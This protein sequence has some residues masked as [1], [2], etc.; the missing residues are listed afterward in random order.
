MLWCTPLFFLIVQLGGMRNEL[1]TLS[2][3]KKDEILGLVGENPIKK[4][5][6]CFYKWME[7]ILCGAYMFLYGTIGLKRHARRWKIIP[8]MVGLQQAE[9]KQISSWCVVIICWLFEWLQVNWIWKRTVFGRLLP[10][11]SACRKSDEKRCQDFWMMI[12]RSATRRCV[13]ISSSIFKLKQTCFVK[14]LL[15][16]RHVFLSTIWKLKVRTASGSFWHQ[17]GW[18]KQES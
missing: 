9:V 13:R 4:H 3:M 1:W 16:M 15:M 6:K 17:Q 7:V 11:I 12:R 8:E 5:M 18:R 2:K 10:K 14:S